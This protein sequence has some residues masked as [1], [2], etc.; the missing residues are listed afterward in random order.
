MNPKS[1][2]LI[3]INISPKILEGAKCW[4]LKTCCNKAI[5][6]QIQCKGERV[7]YVAAAAS[8]SFL[9]FCFFRNWI[10]KKN[11]KKKNLFW[12]KRRRSE[13]HKDKKAN[14]DRD[15]CAHQSVAASSGRAA[16][17]GGV[18]LETETNL[19]LWFVK[20]HVVTICQRPRET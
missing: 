1:K 9:G 8:Q 18:K 2:H 6:I 14:L 20:T 11:R 7:I 5:W 13:T 16:G 3:S 17:T 19:N 15:N 10:K 4:F 12:S